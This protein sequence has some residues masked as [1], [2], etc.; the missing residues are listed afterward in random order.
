V[1]EDVEGRLDVGFA[2]Q[3]EQQLKNIVRAVRVYHVLLDGP[4]GGPTAMADA[5]KVAP[6]GLS[7]P[8]K[9]SIAVLP[10]QN[11]SADP[12]QEFFADGVVEDIIANLARYQYFFVIARNSTF[13]YKGRAVDVKQVG[14]EL[15]VRYVLEGSVR[16]MGQRLRISAQLIDATTSNHIWADRFDGGVEDLFDLQDQVTSS[17]VGAIE[18]EIRRVETAWAIRRPAASVDTYLCVMRGLAS[19]NKWSRAGVDEALRLAYQAT[20][21]DADF[22]W[23]KPGPGLLHHSRFQP[24][25]DRQRERQGRDRKAGGAGDGCWP[26]GRLGADFQRLRTCQG[27]QRSR[28]RSRADR[29]R[30]GLDAEFGD[31]AR[32][33]R[34]RPGLARRARQ[35]D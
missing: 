33:Q 12:E 26:G 1:Q 32:A 5:T 28:W 15:G 6:A 29:P 21:L 31:S 23:P 24:L 16:T 7:L 4:A 10:F 8:D 2:D 27:R 30:A 11:M 22:S 19:I 25:V 35:G 18:P 17:V 13:T 9:P 3:G 20:E 14:R 34:I